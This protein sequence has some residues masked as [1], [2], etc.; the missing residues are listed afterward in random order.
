MQESYDREENDERESVK[1]HRDSQHFK[2]Q[3][4]EHI[5]GRRGK[6]TIF[7]V[8]SQYDGINQNGILHTDAGDCKTRLRHAFA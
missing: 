1:R 3:N 4:S 2:R 6:F 8:T 5:L 7:I